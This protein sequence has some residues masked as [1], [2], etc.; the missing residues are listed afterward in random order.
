MGYAHRGKG[1]IY[2]PRHISE[3]PRHR[4]T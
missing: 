4:V 2:R 1:D 3:Q